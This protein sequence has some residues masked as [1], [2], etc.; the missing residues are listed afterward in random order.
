MHFTKKGAFDLH[1]VI[2]VPYK[3]TA[4]MVVQFRLLHN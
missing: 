4:Q 1:P 2:H 3:D